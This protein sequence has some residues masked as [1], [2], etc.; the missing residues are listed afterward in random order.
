[1]YEG[2]KGAGA[3]VTG[4]VVLPNTGGN[5]ILTVIAITSIVVGAIILLSTIARL[6]VSRM[7]TK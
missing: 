6:V 3:V 2:G 1:M 7:I 5:E 4:G